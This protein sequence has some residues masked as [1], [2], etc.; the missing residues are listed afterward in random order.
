MRSVEVTEDLKYAVR[1]AEHEGHLHSPDL[2]GR[3]SC[4]GYVPD[5][6]E[7]RQTPRNES[8]PVE[9]PAESDIS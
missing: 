7:Q 8:C 3:S 2:Q 9:K 4:E 6:A 5:R 1:D